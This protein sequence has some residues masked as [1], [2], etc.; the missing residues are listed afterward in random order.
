VILG[1]E[2]RTSGLLGV[3]PLEPFPQFTFCYFSQK[4]SYK[5]KFFF[6]AVLGFE[7]RA[8]I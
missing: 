1:V 4:A 5:N 2:L 6:L 7:L 8:S 3:L